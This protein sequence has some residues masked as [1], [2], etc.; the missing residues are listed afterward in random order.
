MP[1]F[2]SVLV[3]LPSFR[4][5]LC[6]EV[7]KFTISLED[8]HYCVSTL[9]INRFITLSLL[10]NPV[11]GRSPALGNP[12]LLPSQDINEG[13]ISFDDQLDTLLHRNT[14]IIHHYNVPMQAQPDEC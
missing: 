11:L 3:T 10:R 4:T 12:T 1:N 5:A 2:T 9:P 14:L 7:F 13:C 6:P 8:I